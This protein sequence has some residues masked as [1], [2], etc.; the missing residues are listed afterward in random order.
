MN[1][2]DKYKAQLLANSEALLEVATVL[3]SKHPELNLHTAC[4]IVTQAHLDMTVALVFNSIVIDAPKN[5]K[6][7]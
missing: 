6:G 7:K 3:V 5:L 1:M 4:S 2:P